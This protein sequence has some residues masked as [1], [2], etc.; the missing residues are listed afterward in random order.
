MKKQYILILSAAIILALVIS[1]KQGGQFKALIITGQSE[2]NWEASSAAVKQILDETGLFSSKIMVTP[3]KGEDMS[4]FKPEFSKFKLV[5]L[6]YDGDA[7]PKETDDALMDYLNNGGGIVVFN[8]KSDPG[9][10]VSES[11][12]ISKR[13]TFEIRT[14]ITD[15]PVTKGLPVR[16]LHPDDVIVQGLKPSGEDVRVLA[17]AFSDTSLGGTGKAEPV[18]VAMNY[19]KGRIFSTLIGLPGGEGDQALH[20][21]GSIVTLQRGAE[22][23]A[24]GAVTQSVP[25]D[26]PTAAAVVLRTDFKEITLGMAFEMIAG[27]D[28]QKGTRY[29]TYIQNQIR[30]AGGN[31]EKLLDLEKRMVKVL[32]SSEATAESKK[33]MLRELSWMGSDYCISSIKELVEVPELKDEAEFALTRLNPL[34]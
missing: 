28:I 10:A 19:G 25:S 3:S 18:L 34:N 13:H 2:H 8:S 32:T 23:A 12:T 16:W 6:D 5:V 29:Y 4:G 1:C 17:T 31:M 27:Y 11:V 30:N 33:L 26:F 9:E 21:A 7:W 24:T 15:H 20:C 14:R 22:W